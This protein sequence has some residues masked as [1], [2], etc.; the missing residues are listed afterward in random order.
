[1][2]PF[3]LGPVKHSVYQLIQKHDVP[4][5]LSLASPVL[6]VPQQHT[7]SQM[8]KC[9]K[10]R[11]WATPSRWFVMFVAA[12]RLLMG[13]LSTSPRLSGAHYATCLFANKTAGK[14]S[15]CL[16]RSEIGLAFNCICNPMIILAALVPISAALS[17]RMNTNA[18][19]IQEEEL[20]EDKGV[21]RTTLIE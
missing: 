18:I 4:V 21:P 5:G 13:S 16:E 10:E 12:S 7:N 1:M 11:K 20:D 3:D 15:I 6:M 8:R 19:Y 17:F 9:E 14:K 2:V